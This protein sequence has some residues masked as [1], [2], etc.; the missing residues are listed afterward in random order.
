MSRMVQRGRREVRGPAQL[1][2]LPLRPSVSVSQTRFQRTL[3][4]PVTQG[5]GLVCW[6]LPPQQL[7]CGCWRASSGFFQKGAACGP[8]EALSPQGQGTVSRVRKKT[9]DM[10]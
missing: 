5:S 3:P 4:S 2:T 8:R 9:K 1:R 10:L 7:L 6:W